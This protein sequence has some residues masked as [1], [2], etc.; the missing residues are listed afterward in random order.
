M[1]FFFFLRNGTRYFYDTDSNLLKAANVRYA[2]VELSY[3]LVNVTY[4]RSHNFKTYYHIVR[5]KGNSEDMLFICTQ[6]LLIL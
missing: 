6:E 1:F 2:V 3:I 5:V 4:F